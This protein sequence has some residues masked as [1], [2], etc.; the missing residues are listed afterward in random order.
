[1]DP[2]ESLE[3]SSTEVQNPLVPGASNPNGGIP[4]PNGPPAGTELGPPNGQESSV[5]EPSPVVENV[6]KSDVWNPTY[7]NHL[8]M[9]S[10]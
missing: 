5:A 2:R 4:S 6:L 10:N 7:S 1:M 8:S 3:R 9:Y